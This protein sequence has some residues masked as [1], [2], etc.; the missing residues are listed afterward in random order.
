MERLIAPLGDKLGALGFRRHERPRMADLNVIGFWR[1]CTWNSNRAVAVLRRPPGDVAIGPYCQQAKWKLL[2]CTRFI[3]FLY[4]VGLQIVVVGEWPEH[5][6]DDGRTLQQS[7]DKV[8]NQFI[9]LQSLFSV[10]ESSNRYACA[11]TWGQLVTGR[12]QDAIA[13]SLEAAGIQLVSPD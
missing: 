5:A 8:S 4:E 10:D 1:R 9:V 11:R 7:V 12:F 13:D 6:P 2:R 3:P